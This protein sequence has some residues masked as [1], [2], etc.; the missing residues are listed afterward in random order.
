MAH[1]LNIEHVTT[2]PKKL[3]G[4][5]YKATLRCKNLS[6]KMLEYQENVHKMCSCHKN[7]EMDE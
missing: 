4:K 3:N 7:V 5:L 6:V 2:E 1:R